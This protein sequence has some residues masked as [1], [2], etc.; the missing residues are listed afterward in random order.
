LSEAEPRALVARL[1]QLLR[2]YG[3]VRSELS[4]VRARIAELREARRLLEERRPRTVFR[5]V[6]GLM[7]EV[8]LE[9]ALRYIGEELEVLELRLKR[10]EEQ[11]KSLARTIREIEEKLGLH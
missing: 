10:L 5:E 6:G 8:G 4:A 7:V 1:E 2:E 11:E 3:L 9:E